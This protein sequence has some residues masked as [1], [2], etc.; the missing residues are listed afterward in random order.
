MRT[1]TQVS[2]NFCAERCHRPLPCS[3]KRETGA[4]SVPR[5]NDF[6]TACESLSLPARL[7]DKQTMSVL[8]SNVRR[9]T[10]R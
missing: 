9:I 10:S 1:A 8:V 2:F 7:N 6:E 3:S 4:M 5:P